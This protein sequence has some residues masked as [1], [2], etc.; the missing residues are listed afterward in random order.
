MNIH[1]SPTISI[2]AYRIVYFPSSVSYVYVFVFMDVSVSVS[3]HSTPGFV[4]AARTGRAGVDQHAAR[5]V[6]VRHGPFYERTSPFAAEH[7]YR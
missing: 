3:V 1:L 2:R 5:E 4:V 7:T 6:A